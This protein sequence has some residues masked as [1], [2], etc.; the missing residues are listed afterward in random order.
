MLLSTLVHRARALYDED[1]LQAE[2]VVLRS[3]FQQNNKT[4]DRSIETSTAVR[5]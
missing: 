3:I 4:T 5:I 2:L 1:S